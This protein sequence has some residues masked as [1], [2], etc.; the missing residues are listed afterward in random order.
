MSEPPRTGTGTSPATSPPGSSTSSAPGRDGGTAQELGRTAICDAVAVADVAEA[1]T[2]PV[3]RNRPELHAGES[4][5]AGV[6]RCEYGYEVGSKG[7]GHVWIGLNPKASL[8]EVRERTGPDAQDATVAG[9]PGLFYE[10]A[11]GNGHLKVSTSAG[12]LE[13]EIRGTIG[14]PSPTTAEPYVAVAE[15]TMTAL[16]LS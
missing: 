2:L 8:D 1:S 12:L 5:D 13:I 9:A 14:P 16:Q 15:L 7:V 3:A 10:G 4:E 11:Y 6:V